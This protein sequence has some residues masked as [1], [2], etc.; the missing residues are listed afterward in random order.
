MELHAKRTCNDANMHLHSIEACH[1]PLNSLSRQ[2]SLSF[3]AAIDLT[4]HGAEFLAS[5]FVVSMHV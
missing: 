2:L 3:F 1:T 4:V 5:P